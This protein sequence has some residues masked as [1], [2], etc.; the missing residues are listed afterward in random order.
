MRKQLATAL[1]FIVVLYSSRSI[2]RQNLAIGR[3]PKPVRSDLPLLINMAARQTS[4]SL[5]ALNF[6]RLLLKSLE[7]YGS[8]VRIGHC[9]IATGNLLQ[10]L[11]VVAGKPESKNRTENLTA[12]NWTS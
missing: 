6:F 3:A 1:L 9:S 10:S 7:I 8:M 2:L 4:A 12:K 5:A 11:C